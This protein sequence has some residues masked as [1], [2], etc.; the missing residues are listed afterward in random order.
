MFHHRNSNGTI[1]NTH[2]ESYVLYVLPVYIIKKIRA[3]LDAV[4]PVQRLWSVEAYN[5]KVAK[6][7]EKYFEG[8][9]EETC[10]WTAFE[11]EEGGRIKD[12]S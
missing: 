4:I 11:G 1:L 12:D 8:G 3:H 5:E 6:R 9:M 2:W 7:I 10:L